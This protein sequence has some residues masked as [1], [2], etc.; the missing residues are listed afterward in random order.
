MATIEKIRSEIMQCIRT[1][2]VFEILNCF[3]D[4]F[5]KNLKFISILYIP[6]TIPLFLPNYIL[7]SFDFFYVPAIGQYMRGGGGG[8]KP[9]LREEQRKKDIKVQKMCKKSDII[10]VKKVSIST[11]SC[12]TSPNNNTDR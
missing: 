8:R 3:L 12:L 2:F 10:G 1:I 9:K 5:F 11:M 6:Q 7:C 4:D